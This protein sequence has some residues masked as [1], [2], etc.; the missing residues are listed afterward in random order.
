MKQPMKQRMKRLVACSLAAAFVAGFGLA[1]NPTSGG[2]T[3]PAAFSTKYGNSR[4]VV[5]M[6]SQPTRY[7]QVFLGSELPAARRVVGLGLRFDE[8]TSFTH[9]G[10]STDIEIRLG[11]TTKSPQTMS[12]NFAQNDDV[13]S[14]GLQLVLPRSRVPLDD[15]LRGRSIDPAKF[16]V[17]IPFRVPFSWNPALKH[18]LLLEIRAFGHSQGRSN[19]VYPIDAATGTTTSRL[20]G[21]S[22]TSTT[23]TLVKGQG[24]IV[25]LLDKITPRG[26]FRHFGSGCPGSGGFG[27]V[28][29]PRRGNFGFGSTGRIGGGNA[30]TQQIIESA[31]V[32]T[33]QV[34]VGHA[35]R[36]GFGIFDI[37][38]RT[39]KLEVQVGAT[40]RNVSTM[41]ATFAHNATSALTTVLKSTAVD[42]PAIRH[43]NNDPKYFSVRIPWTRPF[44]WAA[45]PGEHLLIQVTRQDT[46]A[47]AYPVD[48][49]KNTLG[50]GF[51]WANS[52]SATS[53]RL[54][55]RQGHALLLHVSGRSTPTPPRI[56]REGRPVLGTTS[57]L[58]VEDAAPRAPIALLL[59]ASNSSWGP[60]RLPFSLAA[61]GGQTCTLNVSIDSMSPLV[62]D[63]YGKQSFAL[64]IPNVA[65]LAGL[66]LHSQWMI[67]DRAAN[68]LGLAFSEGATLHLG[69]F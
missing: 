58:M 9:K 7:Q 48:F 31:E 39:V 26:S 35:Y 51:L 16:E 46:L 43:R 44:G 21:Q 4:N 37:P 29:V 54:F 23:G 18:N 10:L 30:K 22:P 49:F 55:P 41:S 17:Q 45:R 47:Q 32:G 40:R 8:I 60:I 13:T 63:I 52:A 42:Y 24:L 33:R 15:Q 34:F 19:Y 68:T 62:S 65:G 61:F 38:A 56:E 6:T 5:P 1:Q 53:G 11:Y 67:L 14:P 20:F 66:R 2:G 3:L 57:R 27:G 50:I 12:T 36:T 69:S 59:G 64:A 28:I 25:C